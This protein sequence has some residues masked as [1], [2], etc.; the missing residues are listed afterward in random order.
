MA[1]DSKR[2]PLLCI[3]QK[4]R[5]SMLPAPKVAGKRDAEACLF[6]RP[7]ER[8]ASWSLGACRHAE[9]GRQTTF[10]RMHVAAETLGADGLNNIKIG[11]KTMEIIKFQGN[12]VLYHIRHDLRELPDEKSY[13]NEA[14]NPDLTANNYSLV[15]RGKTAAEVNRYRKKIEKEIFRYNRKNIVRACECVIQ[16][17]SDCPLDQKAAF[18]KESYKY[19]VSTLPMGERCVFVAQVHTDERHHAPDGSMISKDH[20]HIMYLPG[21]PDKKHPG[22]E[23]KLCADQLMK[24][25][26]LLALHPG[27]QKHLDNC[28]IKATVYRKKDGDGKAI[29]LSVKQLKELTA[30]TGIKLDHSLSVE[31]LSQIINSNILKEKQIEG[32]QKQLRKKEEELSSA[33]SE[34][35]ASKQQLLAAEAKENAIVSVAKEK[36]RGMDTEFKN[37]TEENRILKE[38]LESMQASYEA[39][40]KD[41][42]EARTKISNLEKQN[43]KTINTGWGSLP[44]WGNSQTKNISIEEEKI[45]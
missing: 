13:G 12:K 18:F 38:K 23:Y 20:L 19:F 6:W 1:C 8:H 10:D 42:L 3:G 15:D 22:F 43:E 31:E 26:R 44:G 5:S 24:K 7:L 37:A 28:G 2:T 16:C 29:A 4:R 34:L 39:K 32:F 35:S 27:L 33:L 36:V 17:P 30:R 21:V 25:G 9:R 45:W 14:I 41:L 11:G 40:E